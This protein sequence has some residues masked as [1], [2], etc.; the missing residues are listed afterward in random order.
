MSA[1]FKNYIW[2]TNLG[3]ISPNLFC[4]SPRMHPLVFWPTFSDLYASVWGCC[5]HNKIITAYSSQVNRQLG[6]RPRKQRHYTLHYAFLP[7]L[8]SNST[9]GS[10]ASSMYFCGAELTWLAKN[11]LYAKIR[12]RTDDTFP[13]ETLSVVNVAHS[14][15]SAGFFNY[16]SSGNTDNCGVVRSTPNF[17]SNFKIN[18]LVIKWKLNALPFLSCLVARQPLNQAVDFQDLAW[19]T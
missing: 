2:F 13:T 19:S 7:I 9:L 16:L 17:G 14:N 11:K 3:F 10:S 1:T 5:P 15:T 6:P 4:D 12:C 18:K 8:T